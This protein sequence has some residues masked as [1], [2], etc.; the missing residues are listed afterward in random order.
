MNRIRVNIQTGEVTTI[1]YTPEEIA[2]AIE[3]ENS[4]PQPEEPAAPTLEDL[5]AQLAALSAKI[6]SLIE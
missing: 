6:Q 1:P 2:A 3:H 5:Q 4:L